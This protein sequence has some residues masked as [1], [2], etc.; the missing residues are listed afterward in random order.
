MVLMDRYGTIY[1]AK[2][3]KAGRFHHTSL[4]AGEPAAFAGEFEVLDGVI[5]WVNNYSGHY[6]TPESQLPQ[7]L[8][9]LSTLGVSTGS[10][11]VIPFF[12]DPL[13]ED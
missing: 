2:I 7:F 3:I 6:L 13:A 5:Q 9:R 10:I 12:E 11:K 1:A 8:G 4:L